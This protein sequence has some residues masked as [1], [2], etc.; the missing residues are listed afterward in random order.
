MKYRLIDYITGNDKIQQ[1]SILS[2]KKAAV[3]TNVI[4]LAV[5]AV[6]NSF[7]FFVL[8]SIHILFPP[9]LEHSAV[10]VDLA[11]NQRTNKKPTTD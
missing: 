1:F 6:E 7:F 9:S 2:Y 4:K 5:I 11:D 3:E 8:Q 10:F